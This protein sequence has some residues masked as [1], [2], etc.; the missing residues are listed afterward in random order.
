VKRSGIIPLSEP[1]PVLSRQCVVR[2][3]RLVKKTV[4]VSDLR[5]AYNTAI[6]LYPDKLVEFAFPYRRKNLSL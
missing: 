2:L 4:L 5:L 3:V 6:A 1:Y